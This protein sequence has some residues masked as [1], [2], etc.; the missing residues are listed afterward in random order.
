MSATRLAFESL[1]WLTG[2]WLLWRIPRCRPGRGDPEAAAG[3]SVIVPARDEEATLPRLLASLAEQEPPPGEILV[4]DDHSA[5]ATPTVARRAGATV[6]TAPPLPAGWTGKAWACWTGARSAGGRTLVFLDADTTLDP[7]GLAALLDE[8]QRRGGLV[9]AAPDHV[10]E[11]PYEQLSAFFNVVAMMGLD[12]FDPLRRRRAPRGA[13]GPCLVTTVD[14]YTAVGGHRA[15]RGKVVEDVA[16][17]RRYTAAG[18]RLTCLGG[19]GA[20]RIRMYPAG[21]SQLVEGWTK[22]F[23]GGAGAARPTT[24]LLVSIW[25]SGCISAPWYLA[26]AGSGRGALAGPA[27]GGLYAAYAIQLAW[28]LGRIGRFRRATAAAYPVPLAFFLAV[29]AGSLVLTHVRGMVTW[30]GRS[31]ATRPP[32]TTRPEPAPEEQ[33]ATG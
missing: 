26:M 11:R 3:T 7:G 23:A 13:F 29:F 9:S 14:D 17:A 33:G 28:M 20:V 32:P 12:A 18:R 31:I 15:V 4:V 2:V 24:F 16:L 10:T 19:R 8:H 25:L 6:V 1:R 22:N 27:A 30:R 5:D 21:P